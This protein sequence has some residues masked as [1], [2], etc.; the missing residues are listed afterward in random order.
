MSVKNKR[1]L[2]TAGPT[3]VPIDSVRVISN[4]ATG[5]TGI[6]LARKLQ[7]LGAEVNLLLGPVEFNV[8]H[9]KIRVLRFRFFDEL[10]DRI[11]EEL[12]KRHFD[13]VFHAAAVSDYRPQG[14]YR[15]KVKSGLCRWQL[16]L[17]PTS[18]IIKSIKRLDRDIFLVGFKFLPQA[19]KAHLIQQ[20]RMLM[21]ESDCDCV[22]ANTL[23]S[24][25]YR[26]WIVKEEDV[27]GGY[28]SRSELIGHLI[29]A[30]SKHRIKA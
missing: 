22:V 10:C 7:R 9:D 12:K 3:W 15:K 4:R 16:E 26:A 1:I 20:A 18:K 30:I 29:R 5:K 25:D 14:R 24:N 27:S 28:H 6:L 11:K 23:V 17:V 2:I 19:S 8:V 21:K 13:Y